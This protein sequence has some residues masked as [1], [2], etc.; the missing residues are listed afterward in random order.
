M[1][2]PEHI[3]LEK[4]TF[5]PNLKYS[6]GDTV[7]LKTDTDRKW[8]M[9]IINFEIEE[10]L[11]NDYFVKWLNSQGKPEQAGFPE[12]CLMIEPTK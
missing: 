4:E 2:I 9:L 8:Q 6:I 12:E 5:K 3:Q 11:C 10:D 1:S 7:Y